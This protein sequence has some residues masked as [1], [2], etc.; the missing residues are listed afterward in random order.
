ML[1]FLNNSLVPEEAAKVSVLDRGFLYGDGVFETLRVYSGT[2]F[3]CN[4]HLDRLFQ[5]AEA[6]YL[7]LP[8]TRDYLIEALYKTLEAN[9]LND[10]YLRLSVTRGVSEPGLDIGGC[11]SSTLTI[12]AKEF[13]GYPDNLYQSGI[14]A[15]VVNTRRIPASALNPAIKSLN[16]LNNI[17]ARVEATRLNA[18]EAIML[19]M[20]GYVAEGT[21][22]NIFMVKDGIVKTPPLSAGILNGVTRSIVIDLLKENGIPV[23]EQAFYPNEFYTA[24]E[25]FVTSTLYEV[26]PMTSINGS[27]VGSGQPGSLTQTILN[28]FRRLTT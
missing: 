23:I 3:H 19:N 1:I 11:P 15:A 17:M 2:I 22:S 18:A 27:A 14:R 4:D 20:E 5:S 6:I 26:M 9:H 16:F 13:S 8:F 10:A 21:V 24:D 25:C 28:L 12:I 7:Q